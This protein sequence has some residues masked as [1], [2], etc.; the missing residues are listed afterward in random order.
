MALVVAHKVAATST[1]GALATILAPAV[2][3]LLGITAGTLYQKRFCPAFDLRT[4]SVVQFL[5]CLAVTAALAWQTET[6]QVHWTGAFVFALGWLVFV[7]SLGVAVA[8]PMVNPKAMQLICS[9]SGSVKLLVQSDDGTRTLLIKGSTRKEQ[10]RTEA[11]ET[12][13]DGAGTTT[14]TLVDRFVPV[15]RAIDMTAG[16]PDY[17]TVVEIR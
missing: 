17:G 14:V 8:S 10:M 2:L 11:Y 13:E 6:M 3:A 4:G 7:L 16:S 5:P 1:G 15:I 12:G 9:A